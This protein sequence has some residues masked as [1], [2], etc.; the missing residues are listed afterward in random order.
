M[1]TR[2]TVSSERS[3]R[4]TASEKP[5]SSLALS[6]SLSRPTSPRLPERLRPAKAGEG[7]GEGSPK[8]DSQTTI[9]T[10]ALVREL[11]PAFGLAPDR[12][13]VRCDAAARLRTEARHAAGLMERGSV[14]LHPDR[15]DPGTPDGR[16][17]LAH[18]LVHLAQRQENQLVPGAAMPDAVEAEHEA[19]VL[20]AAFVHRGVL[21]RPR[22][23]LPAGFSAARSTEAPPQAVPS[24]ADRLV[25]TAQS[26]YRSEI[27]RIRHLLYTGVF[28]W[29]V[30]DSE[31][32]EILSI[33][34]GFS[35]VTARAIIAALPE[36]LRWKLA[37][38]VS[39]GHWK[40]FR[41]Q[42]LAAYAA[43]DEKDLARLS[44]GHFRGMSFYGFTDEEHFAL[45]EVLG[46]RA[47]LH[48]ELAS[49]V[50]TPGERDAWEELRT[51]D[52]RYDEDTELKNALQTAITLEQTRR[53]RAERVTRDDLAP[54]LKRWRRILDGFW[55]T[56]AEALRVLDEIGAYLP[57][58][59][60]VEA[61]GDALERAGLLDDL[62]GNIPADRIYERPLADAAAGRPP[63]RRKVLLRLAG[64]RPP[65][66]NFELAKRFLSYRWYDWAITSDEAFLAFQ[67][68]KVLPSGMQTAFFGL[69]DGKFAYRL[70]EQMSQSM[71]EGETMN[72]Y[73]GGKDQ[74][75]LK[76]IQVQLLDDSV[77]SPRAIG[78]GGSRFGRLQSLIS[79][80]I[81]G[82]EHEWVF[83]Q[84]RRR[85]PQLVKADLY[86]DHEFLT[87]IIEKF[88]LYRSHGVDE[89]GHPYLRERYEP[90]VLKGVPFTDDI[91]EAITQIPVVGTAVDGLNFFSHI[92]NFLWASDGGRIVGSLFTQSLG[93]EHLNL[94]ELQEA[95][96]GN[97]LGVRFKPSVRRGKLPRGRRGQPS[98][99]PD[100][101]FA[102][103]HW[104]TKRGLLEARIDD[105]RI[106][107][108]RYPIENFQVQTGE[109]SGTGLKVLIGY[110]TQSNH[111]SPFLDLSLSSLHITDVL[112]T[113][114]DFMMGVNSGD[115]DDVVVRMGA[116]SRNFSDLPRPSR[117][118]DLRSL[119]SL[120]FL[121]KFID[122]PVLT[123]V[124]S[125]GEP[126]FRTAGPRM[127]EALLEPRL[128]MDVTVTAGRT[129][130]QGLFE[131]T[132]QFVA[133]VE[134]S[135]LSIRGG[136]SLESYR[137]ALEKTLHDYDLR[138][139][140]VEADLH[141]APADQLIVRSHRLR[142][143]RDAIAR[144]LEDTRH[145][146]SELAVLRSKNEKDLTPADRAR[147]R[148]LHG[149]VLLDIGDLRVRGLEG[150]VNLEELHLTDVH[151]QGTSLVGALSLLSPN[152]TLA[153][154]LK[155][156]SYRP[157]IVSR[158]REPSEFT[159]DLGTFRT[160]P[161]SVRDPMPTL[162]EVDEELKR[163][164]GR[165]QND[166]GDVALVE[167]RLRLQA[168]RERV[169]RYE[170]LLNRGLENLDRNQ[171]QELVRLR[172]E[173]IRG[174]G[175]E[176][177]SLAAKDASLTLG[178]VGLSKEGGT[179]P[180]RIDT[181]RVRRAGL[182]ARHLE[183]RGIRVPEQ[184]LEVRTI[185]GD[186]VSLQYDRDEAG[187]RLH[188]EGTALSVEGV[189]RATS[190]E[191]L[192]QERKVLSEQVRLR[193][194]IALFLSPDEIEA[195]LKDAVA[196]RRELG[197]A[198][199]R[200]HLAQS[201][202]RSDPDADARVVE[203]ERQFELWKKRAGYGGLLAEQARLGQD[204]ARQ[205]LAQTE[206][207]EV[208]GLDDEIRGLETRLR[209]I[210]AWLKTLDP[211]KLDLA[212]E[213][214][215]LQIALPVRRRLD[216][217][218]ADLVDLSRLELQ[219]R[220]A[221]TRLADLRA[222]HQPTADA[223]QEVAVFRTDLDH[224]HKRIVLGSVVA[225]D[226]NVRVSGLGNLFGGDTDIG[227]RLR[228]GLAIE[229]GRTPPVG[230]LAQTPW[231][232][233]LVL[234][235]SR[236][237]GLAAARVEA[238]N[239][240][241]RFESD[242]KRIRFDGLGFDSLSLLQ[243]A[244]QGGAHRVFSEGTST[245][246]NVELTGEI[247]MAD[248][249]T[250]LG[251]SEWVPT[252]VH[253]KR[254]A[255]GRIEAERLGY[256][257]TRMGLFVEIL[258]GAVGGILVTDTDVDLAPGSVPRLKA[259][260]AVGSLEQLQ[261]TAS[262]AAALHAQGTLE[263]REVSVEYVD[264][265]TK[266]LLTAQ[267]EEL[268][269]SGADLTFGSQHIRGY[270]RKL[271]GGATLDA[272]GT[273]DLHD[274]QVQQVHLGPSQFKAGHVHAAID[275][276]VDIRGLKLDARV[277]FDPIQGDPRIKRIQVRQLRFDSAVLEGIR[278][279]VAGT[280]R[281]PARGIEG[282]SP[283][284]IDLAHAD[285]HDFYLRGDNL[286]DRRFAVDIQRNYT[287]R[288][289]K[290]RIG[291]LGSE[292]IKAGL[293]L[294]GS[295][296]GG[297]LYGPDKTAI[298]LGTITSL[299]GGFKGFG[300]DTG[301]SSSSDFKLTGGI[302]LR[303]D[304]MV[305]QDIETEGTLLSWQTDYHSAD[306]TSLSLKL[307]SLTKMH[308]QDLTFEY[309]RVLE[310]K[311][312][313]RR[314]SR[315]HLNQLAIENIGSG[316][317]R[318][319]GPLTT[320]GGAPTV[321]QTTVDATG[322]T[323]SKFRL[324]EMDLDLT[325]FHESQ[326][327]DVAD[328]RLAQ[329]QHL[330]VAIEKT[331]GSK[332]SR[333]EI[334]GTLYANHMSGK[335]T[336]D[337]VKLGPDKDW[338]RI[339]GTFHL[340]EAGL[341]EPGVTYRSPDGKEV[342]VRGFADTEADLSLKGVDATFNEN[343]TLQVSADDV[344][345][346]NLEVT[347][348]NLKVTL[349]TV[350]IHSAIAG[351]RGLGLDDGLEFLGATAKELSAEH[352]GLT[353]DIDRTP[354]PDDDPSAPS[355]PPEKFTAEPISGLQG[356]AFYRYWVLPSWQ[357]RGYVDIDKGQITNISSPSLKYTPGEE[358]DSGIA[359]RAVSSLG[360]FLAD[361]VVDSVKGVFYQLDLRTLV[362]GLLQSK[363]GGGGG[364][365]GSGKPAAKD[366]TNLYKLKLD[367]EP[368]SFGGGMF[369]TKE[370]Y[371]RLRGTGA[372]S[373]PLS[374]HSPTAVG[375]ELNI[376]TAALELEKI[377]YNFGPPAAPRPRGS[378]APLVDPA[379]TKLLETGTT[380]FVNLRVTLSSLAQV[381]LNVTLEVDNA[382]I[383]DVAF[384]NVQVL[385][386]GVLSTLASPADNP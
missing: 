322:S 6:L 339:Q 352:P 314:L 46:D 160:G 27:S 198:Y 355:P 30:R 236:L 109:G 92:L 363:P 134:V 67:L 174:S 312:E 320:A 222:R 126:V 155:G 2:A 140:S 304:A 238:S 129:A 241:G 309:V 202:G 111:Q 163:L 275:S 356:R 218:D 141:G 341:F 290:V 305:V 145:K 230:D 86:Q 258:S 76:S 183:V 38:N 334:L 255:I 283:L 35:W 171:E 281:D 28:D 331:F 148:E 99:L 49:L 276:G 103:V 294:Q 306:G 162:E 270:F 182:A 63:D 137:L 212:R 114:P 289:L 152:E 321:S 353:V 108:I 189:T 298:D 105:L 263:G 216:A 154:M 110:P 345:V 101:N 195:L 98:R 197:Q 25:A 342:K 184:G 40:L 175:F 205:H 136:D 62:I 350:R 317:L 106:A 301:I 81:A 153:R 39:S 253:V 311:K 292:T 196:L 262:V 53:D 256:A 271:S 291:E 23:V 60:A 330:K 156:E 50:R 227:S 186:K 366:L 249:T 79:M 344:A 22:A 210:E 33:L 357:A 214:L 273:L 228:S 42:I 282:E 302:T 77:W 260:A 45:R 237:P 325:P 133:S 74:R 179:G 121:T 319:T 338:N 190:R 44:R 251:E 125:G 21:A 360:T 245:L 373:S 308:L 123:P 32:D 10:Q 181:S 59:G 73:T 221:E 124:L 235:E 80:A 116:R 54:R 203:L 362:E 47:R 147:M 285:A 41:L 113:Y 278:V 268:S 61:I 220:H 269:L 167:Q 88:R 75:E 383:R 70:T 102:A 382:T 55:I 135:N 374:I 234:T 272:S 69:E 122:I 8:C 166:P 14:L 296:I 299:S 318:Y 66:K 242:A 97:F 94:A 346:K 329:V 384:G 65:Y 372:G 213:I 29:V 191:L 375:T 36:K 335:L 68:V 95:F 364:G 333:T 117:G 187:G 26:A 165:M 380:R 130:L 177:Q 64:S 243:F 286:V 361:D 261:F 143:I 185:Q 115:A 340:G 72:F 378:P 151:G 161:I 239:I 52:V 337:R 100:I 149:G 215:G 231:A 293:S 11:A 211:A 82:G 219:L 254:F 104:D 138:L 51:A 225:E 207:N 199:A 164:D 209:P 204:Y 5:P 240:R 173:V 107:A 127:R 381:V 233:R 208:P 326:M 295:A 118:F 246:A 87:V 284:A 206:G 83:G 226:V 376:A 371:V 280:P 12:I 315:V 9:S 358:D 349:P 266:R 250:E 248:R 78:A 7:C 93:G 13:V 17:L 377:H 16:F 365:G 354:D 34:A 15:Y 217:I 300:L 158:H 119:I 89:D 224:W 316:P 159:L 178:P 139:A 200:Q 112:V 128:P 144:E 157:A 324:K 274:I 252:G 91:L 172:Q 247:R 1:S 131:S 142:Q 96:D 132:G 3:R 359:E 277:E 385:N 244:F 37:E 336:F 328:V 20:A 180:E 84:S 386:P 257:N 327:F 229:G 288:T 192:T 56:D 370:R 323:I 43:L 193:A 170:N 31:V 150:G 19:D 369:G 279:G 347:A 287:V 351:L 223:E 146:E 24:A 264:D 267:V 313:V 343:G 168:R 169:A 90:E 85:Y 310:D 379:R 201:E 57:E 120:P 367:V 303:P 188:A 332:K 18:E 232:R 368:L 4:A 48:R 58:P 348:G 194:P 297:R 307:A 176:I 71:R 259:R 265:G